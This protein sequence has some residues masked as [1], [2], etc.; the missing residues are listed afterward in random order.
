MSE[1]KKTFVE[2][3]IAVQTALK[4]PKGQYNS[5]GKYKYRSAE[6]ILNAVKPLNAEQGLLLTLSDEPLLIGDWHYI[7]A[8]ATITDGII[9][10]SFTAYARESLTKKGMDDS[11]ITGTA[12]SYARKYALNGL[13]L[14]DDTK[15]ADTDE[16]KKQE[17]N[18]KK[19]TKKQLEQLRANFKKIAALKKVSEKSVEAQFLTIIKFDGKIEDLDT[20]IH[21]KLME[22]T[23]RNIYKLENEQ[24]FNDVME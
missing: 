10:E 19:I 16:Y 8:T 14:I 22:L 2:K 6:D 20:E 12:S 3:L 1:D 15:D 11:Q 5:F 7:K 21:H 24:F 4:A 18:V 13:Y 17:K 23:N 9:K